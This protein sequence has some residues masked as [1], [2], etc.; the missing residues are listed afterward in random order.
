MPLAHS[1]LSP[2]A[3]AAASGSATNGTFLANYCVESSVM[4]HTWRCSSIGCS[5]WVDS[6]HSVHVHEG[7]CIAAAPGAPRAAAAGGSSE[8][9][10]CHL[11]ARLVCCWLL[12]LLLIRPT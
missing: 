11:P 7:E 1:L 12:L 9:C 4:A 6:V 8:C 5:T 10:L 2:L 3:A